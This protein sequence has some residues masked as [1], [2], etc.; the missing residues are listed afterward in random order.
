LVRGIKQGPGIRCPRRHQFNPKAV[1]PPGILEVYDRIEKLRPLDV[2]F[3]KIRVGKRQAFVPSAVVG[4][5]MKRSCGPT[6][7]SG[8]IPQAAFA[9]SRKSCP[10]NGDF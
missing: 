3:R 4:G 5:R 6:L 2:G 10:W 7:Y 1:F 9:L 8:S